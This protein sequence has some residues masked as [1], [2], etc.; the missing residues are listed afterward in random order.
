MPNINAVERFAR[1]PDIEKPR[2]IFTRS[3]THKTSGN[4]G[5]VI[6]IYIDMLYPG[7]TVKMET[8]KVVRMQTLLTPIMDN[9]YLDIF[10]FFVPM[11]LTWTHTKEF[12]GENNE[13]A[14]IPQTVYQVPSISSPVDSNGDPIPFETGTLADYMGLPIGPKWTNDAVRRPMALPFRAYSLIMNDFFRSENITDPLN[15]P[16]G[17]ANQTGSNGSNYINDV[18]NG[19]KPFVAA[20]FFDRFTGCLPS[21]QKGP[22]V[23]FPLISGTMAP[24]GTRTDHI[25]PDTDSGFGTQTMYWSRINDG[26]SFNSGD[27]FSV[28]AVAS[29]QSVAPG[30]LYSRAISNSG[31]AI[32]NSGIYPNNLWADLSDTVGAVTVNELRLAFQ[33]QRYYEAIARSG[34]R[35]IELMKGLFGVDS[36]DARLQRPEYLGGNR[37]PIQI[38]EVI[39]QAQATN[40]YLGDLGAMSHTADVHYDFEY[41]TREH[42][43]LI[44]LCVARYDHSYAQGIE[45]FWSRL[46]RESWY[47]PQFANIGEQPVFQDEICATDDN[48]NSE[49][50]FGY[51]EA[52]SDLRYKQDRISAELRPGI[53]N[54]LASW[55]LSDYYTEAPTL[56]DSWLREDPNIVD[57]VL[58]VGH[59][60]SNQYFADFYFNATYTAVLPMYSVPGLIDHY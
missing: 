17:D 60:V 54:T 29:D 23:T 49:V 51:Q 1:V 41:S 5:D 44:G 3:N 31:S 21:P 46:D 8:S 55:H 24:V 56:S 2:S 14:W 22:A 28:A 36:D 58:A 19:G 15:I 27:K 35:Y 12:F 47:I 40:D 34:S 32:S 18:A 38:H 57:R 25:T 37:I 50:V 9:I 6:P 16:V 13:S 30:Q 45:R 59:D 43:F 11:R 52:W 33:L 42:G 10:W 7:T 39:N 48:M 53:S 4:I 26:W 20:K